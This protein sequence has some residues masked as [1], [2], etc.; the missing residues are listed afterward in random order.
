MPGQHELAVYYTCD[1]WTDNQVKEEDEYAAGIA[2]CKPNIAKTSHLG[3][4]EMKFVFPSN[5]EYSTAKLALK[6]A[7]FRFVP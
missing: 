3:V 7:G 6:D 2:G 5:E 4:R 1:G